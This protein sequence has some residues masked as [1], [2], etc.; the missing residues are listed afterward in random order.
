MRTTWEQLHYKSHIIIKC[1]DSQC[2][3]SSPEN[4]TKRYILH[5]LCAPTFANCLTDPQTSKRMRSGYA[6]R[7]KTQIDGWW[8]PSMSNKTHL[9][10]ISNPP[11]D[12]PARDYFFLNKKFTHKYKRYNGISVTVISNQ[13]FGG[14][15]DVTAVAPPGVFCLVRRHHWGN[16]IYSYIFALPESQDECMTIKPDRTLHTVSW[17]SFAF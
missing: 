15:G 8:L 3:Y 13:R 14:H 6:L 4:P 11:C 17:G 16:G 5:H 7:E 1:N 10:N 2:K 9:T 12:T